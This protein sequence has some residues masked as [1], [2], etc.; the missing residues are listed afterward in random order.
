M[1]L[2]SDPNKLDFTCTVS[3]I[4]H[5]SKMINL[6]EINLFTDTLRN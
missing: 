4:I 2:A 3:R 5:D 1:W 6:V